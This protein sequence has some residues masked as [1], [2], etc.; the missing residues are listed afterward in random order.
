MVTGWNEWMA[1]KYTMFG[2]VTFCDVYNDE[3][4]RDIEPSAG[5]GGDNFYMQLARNIRKYKLTDRV[6]YK[7]QKM[8][9]DIDNEESL[10]Q[11]EAVKAH[12]VDFAGDAIERNGQDAVKKGR[13]TDNSNRND[14]TDVKV[15]H[16]NSDLFVYVRTK[17][18]ITAYNGADKNWM[19]L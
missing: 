9:M 14:I 13:Y 7:Y 10:F 16:N 3:Y 2:R 8:T 18:N 6:K 12:Y 17:D 15:V 4:S 5:V 19:T 11:W 1:I